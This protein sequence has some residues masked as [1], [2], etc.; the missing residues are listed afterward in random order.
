MI[1]APVHRESTTSNSYYIMGDGDKIRKR[2]RPTIVCLRCR[3]KKSKCD[4]LLP[5]SNCIK[6]K[7]PEQC[8]YEG[9][10]PP[11]ASPEPSKPEVGLSWSESMERHLQS[12]DIVNRFENLTAST[13]RSAKAIVPRLIFDNNDFLVGINPVVRASDMLNLHMDLQEAQQATASPLRS[14]SSPQYTDMFKSHEMFRCVRNNTR[15]ISLVNV[16]Q[17]EPGARLFW[18]FKDKAIDLRLM[19]LQA[20]S[21][22]KVQDLLAKAR[23]RFSVRFV[24]LAPQDLA[25]I[26]RVDVRRAC[27]DY[28]A[29]LGLLFSSFVYREGDSYTEALRALLPSREIVLAYVNR[30]F[31][32]IYPVYPVVDEDWF[33]DYLGQLLVYSPDGRDLVDVRISC[34]DDLLVLAMLLFMMR[35][36]YLSFMT[37]SLDQNAVILHE[38]R[39]WGLSLADAQ[40]TM[41]AV[42]VGMRLL[43]LGLFGR[44][45]LF[46]ALQAHLL[47]AIVHL[48]LLENEMSMNIMDRTCNVGQLLQMATSLTMDRD[49]IYVYDAMPSDARS[50]NLRRKVW[51]VL[52]RLDFIMSYVFSCPR[53]ITARQFNTKLPQYSPAGCNIGDHGLEGEVIKLMTAIHTILDAGSD[54]LDI[55]LDLRGAHRAVDIVAKVTDLEILIDEQLGPVLLY[56]RTATNRFYLSS[57]LVM[58]QLQVQVVLKMFLSHIY[59]FLHLYYSYKEEHELDFFFFRKLILILFAEMN[60][61]CSELMFTRDLIFDWSF[62]LLMS[63]TILIYLHL[64]AMVGLGFAIRLHCTVFILEQNGDTA[65]LRLL[66]SLTARNETFVLRKLK[67]CKLLSERYMHGWKC[68]KVNGSGYR[69]VYHNSL[70]STDIESLTRAKIWWSD[71]QQM[72]MFNIIPE[73]VPIQ[74]SDVGNVLLQCYYSNRSLDDADLQGADLLRTIQTDNFWIAFN[75]LNQRDPYAALET[76]RNDSVPAQGLVNGGVIAAVGNDFPVPPLGSDVPT[77]HEALDFNFFSTDWSIEEFLNSS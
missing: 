28:G 73:D 57:P 64:V 4:K 55:A 8:S 53:C 26:L 21:D 41:S 74:M 46:L 47:S 67:L 38:S 56:F 48:H 10:A 61:F 75:I 5:C 30:F 34:A 18:R 2:K 45:V 22:D 62:S 14:D 20:F 40:V 68:N 15:V 23:A 9:G 17:Q 42:E 50:Q 76:R 31:L 52:V 7:C 35:L 58:L 54:L 37:N 65:S 12:Q 39:P 77:T 59:Y 44:K 49:P 3:T 43:Q 27:S 6:A 1:S 63:P 66:K 51:Y 13:P 16:S 33:A 32:T 60:Y 70:Y 36:A 69:M 11:R 19:T 29:L 72:E 24:D 71:R 25:N